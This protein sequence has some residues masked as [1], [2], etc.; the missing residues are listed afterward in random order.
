MWIEWLPAVRPS[1]ASR[2]GTMPPSG[3]R[4]L[5]PLRLPFCQYASS[6]AHWSRSTLPPA[7]RID[8][9]QSAR[10]RTTIASAATLAAVESRRRPAVDNGLPSV[11]DDDRRGVFSDRG[12]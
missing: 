10:P 7:A 12:S 5:L 4:E 2:N 6:E 3:Y 11:D 8:T 1:R 9:G